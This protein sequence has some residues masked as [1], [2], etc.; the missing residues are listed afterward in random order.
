MKAFIASLLI[1]LASAAALYERE[2]SVSY[3]GYKV[4]RIATEDKLEDVSA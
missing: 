2:E 3:D 1:S 4:V